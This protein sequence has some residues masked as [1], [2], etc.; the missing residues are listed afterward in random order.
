[1]RLIGETS[2]LIA[3]EINMQSNFVHKQNYILLYRGESERRCLYCG[4]PLAAAPAAVLTWAETHKP[5][6]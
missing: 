5:I 2:R 1:M 3:V 6:C 4:C